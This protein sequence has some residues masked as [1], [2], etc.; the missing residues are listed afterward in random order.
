MITS[1]CHMAVTSGAQSSFTRS[2]GLYTANILWAMIL[3]SMKFEKYS[4]RYIWLWFNHHCDVFR[5]DDQPT[6]SRL[7]YPHMPLAWTALTR[8]QETHCREL[9]EY[10]AL[11]FMSWGR[12]YKRAKRELNSVDQQIRNHWYQHLFGTS[13][14]HIFN[15][16]MKL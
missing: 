7:Y 6:P 16:Q 5:I 11:L 4:I 2:S 15:Y 14:S 13:S 1:D 12:I 9:Y 8:R 10:N 3:Q